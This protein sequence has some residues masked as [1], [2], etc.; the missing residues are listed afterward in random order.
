MTDVRQTAYIGDPVTVLSTEMNSLANDT[1]SALGAEQ[2]NVLGYMLMD[3]QVDL[4]SL[5]PTGADAAIEVYIVPS[6]DGTNYPNYTETGVADEQENSA[7]F[8]GSVTLSLDTEAQLQPI[9]EVT[10]PRGKWKLGIR[11]RANVALAASANA[12]KVRYW[13]YQSV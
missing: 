1:W 6:V 7:F 11:T 2:S 3:I 12:V 10:V 5:L 13:G 9:L 4:G 8:I